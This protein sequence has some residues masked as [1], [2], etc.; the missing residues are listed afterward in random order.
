ML[1]CPALPLGIGW[2][3]RR[4][5]GGPTGSLGIDELV[6]CPGS[7]HVGPRAAFL[8]KGWK[9]PSRVTSAT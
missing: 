2:S 3:G 8:P 5:P 1:P 6:T 4:L 7:T 9:K